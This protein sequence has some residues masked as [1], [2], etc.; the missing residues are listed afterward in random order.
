MC[1]VPFAMIE[2]K[3][4]VLLRCAYIQILVK[5]PI[6]SRAAGFTSENLQRRHFSS[7]FWAVK[8]LSRI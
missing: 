2:N 7:Y 6:F 3:F 1:Y 8:F 4:F 5:E